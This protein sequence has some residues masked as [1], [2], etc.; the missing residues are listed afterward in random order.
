MH[1]IAILFDLDGTLLDTLDDLHAAINHALS[2]VGAAPRT[3]EQVRRFVGN[4][5]A[6]LAQ[7]AL[8]GSGRE[9]QWEQ[10]LAAFQTYYNAHCRVAT[11]PY[12]GIM[13][14]L[15]RLKHEGYPMAVVSNKPDPAVQ[16]LCRDYFGDL[17]LHT[18]GE[19]PGS[20]RKPA[21]DM[22]LLAA[23][24]L[25]TP[26][27]RCVYVGDSEVDVQTAR[28]AG[29]VCLSVTWGFRDREE[30]ARE[31]SVHFCDDARELPE[32]IRQLEEMLC[33]K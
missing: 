10:V 6:K 27:E 15:E 13:E 19:I 31:G 11:G 29:M 5:A 20:P 24:K 23:R 28:N 9:D 18:Q 17:F 14:T 26:A 21:A 33:G 30:M 12:P 25:E 16:I 1:K 7:R 4:G 2:T 8:A 3:R 22:P 32:K